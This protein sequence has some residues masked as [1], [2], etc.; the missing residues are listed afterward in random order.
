MSPPKPLCE[1]CAQ[2]PFHDLV[3]VP[4]NEWELGPGFRIQSNDCPFCGVIVSAF[5]T[6]HQTDFY[7]TTPLSDRPSVSL[8]WSCHSG[9]GDRGAFLLNEVLIC[10]ATRPSS[11][12]GP[13]RNTN[14]GCQR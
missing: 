14:T 1:Y 10:C 2:I 8:R 5:Q 11:R 6:A 12:Q 4:A 13:A 3:N 7:T 9:P